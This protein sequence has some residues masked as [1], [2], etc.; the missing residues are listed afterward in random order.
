MYVSL[1]YSSKVSHIWRVRMYIK[2]SCINNA[3][4]FL[5]RY[6]F[7]RNCDEIRF[8]IRCHFLL[9]NNWQS[10]I[11][12]PCDDKLMCDHKWTATTECYWS[13]V[14]CTWR[15][16]QIYMKRL[17]ENIIIVGGSSC[18]QFFIV[19]FPFRSFVL[20]D[21]EPNNASVWKSF[22]LS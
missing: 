14:I 21:I 16:Y 18:V 17:R 13:R 5:S 8:H 15:K 2:R 6:K 7:I 9:N 10:S 1:D 19:S 20:T 12:K 4:N 22:H 11:L 3:G